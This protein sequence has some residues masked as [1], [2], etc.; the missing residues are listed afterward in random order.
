MQFYKNIKN[1]DKT[2]NIQPISGPN[3]SFPDL[4]DVISIL[5]YFHLLFH[6]AL[7][8]RTHP[9]HVNGETGSSHLMPS[10]FNEIS[11]Y[12]SEIDCS[13]LIRSRASLGRF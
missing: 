2:C 9:S 1:I 8:G 12:N 13:L 10:Q 5:N 6:S 7:E 11:K 3:Q 4:L